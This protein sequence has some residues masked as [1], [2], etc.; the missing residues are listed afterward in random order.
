MS[1]D[2]TG[3]PNGSLQMYS[4]RGVG[5]T[6]RLILNYQMSAP[7]IKQ[8][9]KPTKKSV[10][11]KSGEK[12][13]PKNVATKVQ[14]PPSVK[15]S[16]LTQHPDGPN[17]IAIRTGMNSAALFGAAYLTSKFFKNMEQGSGSF[18]TPMLPA[19]LQRIQGSEAPRPLTSIA[20]SAK[21][22][23]EAYSA[24]GFGAPPT[25]YGM[26]H[27]SRLPVIT[28]HRRR[29]PNGKFVN[30]TNISAEEVVRIVTIPSS[31]VQTADSF[32]K[33]TFPLQPGYFPR[34]GMIARMYEQWGAI[35]PVPG[36]KMPV[37]SPWKILWRTMTPTSSPGS[38][39]LTVDSDLV[40]EEVGPSYIALNNRPCA[41]SSIW[42]PAEFTMDPMQIPRSEEYAGM[43][44]GTP[45]FFVRSTTIP[46]EAVTEFDMG[47]GVAGFF[48]CQ[49]NTPLGVLVAVMNL[50]FH[51]P[52]A[53]Q[54]SPLAASLE[55]SAGRYVVG[56]SF[57][58]NAACA[59]MSVNSP[60]GWAATRDA[61]TLPTAQIYD[62]KSNANVELDII[63]SW[64]VGTVAPLNSTRLKFFVEGIYVV[65][66]HGAFRS[67]SITPSTG[68]LGFTPIQGTVALATPTA[69]TS[70]VTGDTLTSFT[71]IKVTLDAPM[72]ICETAIYLNIATA[73]GDGAGSGSARLI[74]TRMTDQNDYEASFQDPLVGKSSTSKSYIYDDV[75]ATD[76]TRGFHHPSK[77]VREKQIQDINER[78][79]YL[80][81]MRTQVQPFLLEKHRKK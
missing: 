12:P 48:G 44:V 52:V 59:Y 32:Y 10:A 50:E 69:E 62:F 76:G 63:G 17:P 11:A 47:I 9:N 79:K 19:P 43:G 31:Y 72:G 16:S 81:I 42:S 80:E 74:V 7:I 54:L 4:P 55:C 45:S 15:S 24:S 5:R 14:Q 64:A 68:W 78:N 38:V 3:N 36:S 29:L 8:T 57:T 26:N 39:T 33:V 23:N 53:D 37:I 73:A 75:L 22:G 34:A 41:T 25:S 13:T 27:G 20:T 35:D 49:P 2:Y 1:R 71:K 46:K 40:D 60:M 21:L 58:P 65:S 30:V 70:T 77:S 51:T 18:R 6:F 67:G 66:Y 56:G 61:T 28:T